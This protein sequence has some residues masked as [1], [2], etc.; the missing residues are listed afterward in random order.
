[1]AAEAGL[2]AESRVQR[3]GPWWRR[4]KTE[5][6]RVSVREVGAETGKGGS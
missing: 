4:G 2:E 3:L 1:M 6:E 5:K